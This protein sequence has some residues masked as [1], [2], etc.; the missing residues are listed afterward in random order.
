VPTMIEAGIPYYDMGNWYG[1]LMPATTA[2]AIVNFI[3]AKTTD[4]LK[5]PDTR[6][7]LAKA[8]VEALGSRP[9]EF[10]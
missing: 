7:L 8:E 5:C 1:L 6:A 3:N 4:L 10:A 9:Q 2:P